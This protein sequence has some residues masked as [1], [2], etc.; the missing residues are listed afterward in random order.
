MAPANGC[1]NT[2]DEVRQ[3][4]VTKGWSFANPDNIEQCVREGWSDKLKEQA[5]EGCNISGRIR[6]NK[7]VGNLHLSAGRSFQTNYMNVHEL[8]PYLRDGKQHDFGHTINELTFQGDDEYDF[9]KAEQSKSMKKKL[10]IDENPLDGT[11]RKAG[12]SQFMF[13]YFLKVVSTKFETLEGKTVNTHQY[14]AT[15]FERDLTTGSQGSTSE[16]VHVSHL[17]SGMPGMFINY[18]ISPL[19]VVHSETRQSFAH[20]LTSTCAIVGGVL[21]IATIVDSVVFATGRRLKKTIVSGTGGNGYGGSKL[22]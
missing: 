12:S 22:M 9:T 16:G 2:C 7:V 13:Q 19:L 18:E 5:E 3:A 14:S 15:H 1:C 8:V 10:G 11:V 6:V 4:Y 20:F 21:T 17:T